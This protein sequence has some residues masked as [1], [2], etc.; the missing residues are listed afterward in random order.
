MTAPNVTPPLPVIPP[1]PASTSGTPSTGVPP[2]TGSTP[3]GAQD[4]G[5]RYT[6][7]P[8]VPDYLVGKTAAEAADLMT[9]LV[10][11]NQRLAQQTMGGQTGAPPYTAPA[12]PAAAYPT[13]PYATAT[14]PAISKPTAEDF[15]NR[16]AEATEQYAAY[17]EQTR[18][19]PQFAATAASQA[20]LAREMVALRR[21][22][23]FK[24]YGPEIDM[25]L[26]QLAPN[27]TV[28]TPDNINAV[29]DMVRGRHVE[30]LVAEE[31][32]KHQ[33]ALGGA[34]AR[35]DGG[36]IPGASPS[37]SNAVDLEKL[38]MNFQAALKRLNLDQHTIDEFLIGAYVKTGMELTLEAARERWVKQAS[39]GDIVTDGK[40][41]LSGIYQ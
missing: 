30:D 33:N 27:P 4:T 2:A 7:A 38:P 9:Q 35:S 22:E 41:Y 3:S 6:A 31:R 15:M 16:P 17:L 18:W 10:T 1:N 5:F 40:E 19:N 14:I 26:Q 20:Q 39:R 25:A 32:A 21:P 37:G 13:A 23:D 11:Q 28:R 12:Y 36:G 29:V 8:G 24:R 34:A